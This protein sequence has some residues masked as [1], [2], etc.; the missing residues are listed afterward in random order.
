MQLPVTKRQLALHVGERNV[1]FLFSS[2]KISLQISSTPNKTKQKQEIKTAV[3]LPSASLPY[4]HLLL[5]YGHGIYRYHKNEQDS[6]LN[7]SF[8]PSYFLP[9]YDRNTKCTGKQNCFYFILLFLLLLFLENNFFS[10][11]TKEC[12]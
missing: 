2:V 10:N 11:N 12:L 3:Q 8:Y 6:D 9:L 1:H 7:L 5:R 4:L